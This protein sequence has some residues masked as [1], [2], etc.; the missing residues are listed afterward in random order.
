MMNDQHS[1]KVDLGYLQSITVED[2][3]S[4]N[5]FPNQKIDYAIPI[6][7]QS[8]RISHSHQDLWLTIEWGADSSVLP[9]VDSGNRG[10]MGGC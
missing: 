7:T 6:P 10:R 8:Q 4:G 2:I 5:L 1:P 9:D 3:Q